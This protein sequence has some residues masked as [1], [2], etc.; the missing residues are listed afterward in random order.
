METQTQEKSELLGIAKTIRSQ[1]VAT[2]KMALT[3]WGARNFV[4]LSEIKIGNTWFRGG[5]QFE[6]NGLKFQ[7]IIQIRLNGS[8]VYEIEAIQ[9][10][11]TRKNGFV[12]HSKITVEHIKDVFCD[13]LV[14]E[15]D[16]II[17]GK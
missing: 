14:D 10:T 4:F 17:E 5:L 16:L 12:Q 11:Q 3:A 7:G 13:E 8:D 2:D 6:V 9:K 1:I 15:L